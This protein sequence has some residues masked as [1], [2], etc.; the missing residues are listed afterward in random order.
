MRYLDYFTSA[1]HT[2]NIHKLKSIMT[3]MRVASEMLRKTMRWFTLLNSLIMT[4]GMSGRLPSVVVSLLQK[5]TILQM[6]KV[7]AQR[8]LRALAFIFFCSLGIKLSRTE[9]ERS[10]I[11]HFFHA[12][13]QYINRRKF[14]F[15]PNVTKAGLKP[16]RH[17]V[18]GYHKTFLEIAE[19][20]GPI[21]CANPY[22]SFGTKTIMMVS[23]PSAVQQVM[24]DK[25]TYPSRGP[26]GFTASTPLGL[27]GL[28]SGEVH[29]RHRRVIGKFM[30]NKFLMSYTDII[31]EECDVLT[32]KWEKCAKE[33]TVTNGV[34]DLSMITLQIIMR[35]SVG[36]TGQSVNMQYVDEADNE[37]YKESHY[38]L[39]E[40]LVASMFPLVAQYPSQ[41]LRRA[42]KMTEENFTSLMKQAEALNKHSK[43]GP[44]MY[45]ALK[46]SQSASSEDAF[47]EEEV[48]QEMTTI[49]GAGHETTAHT[50]SWCL[51]LLSE[52]PKCMK[53]LQAEV[54]E[55]LEGQV[56][57]Y[58]EVK[59]LE[60]THMVV[61]ETL[62]L[63]P[64]VPIFPRQ[65]AYDTKL[66]G[67]DVPKGTQV[68]IFQSPMNQNPKLWKS[69]EEFNPERFRKLPELRVS[70]AVGIPDGHAYGFIPFGAV[71]SWSCSCHN[72]R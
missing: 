46:T 47:S 48:M 61:Y 49:R 63:Y 43:L 14:R 7:T 3:R 65:A 69:P 40:I 15:P 42:I 51:L 44:T 37:E 27:L 64:T 41:R 11:G 19:K 72:S 20:V 33:K 55:V 34:Y 9:I 32:E 8:R 59:R 25:V 26:S 22:A 18:F 1:F 53:K 35:A 21:A 54:D 70:R 31:K 60:Y 29:T 45:S 2:Y 23:D 52:H 30:S 4:F 39:K 16:W 67:Y 24:T 58:E 10:I 68:F 17:G 13:S 5:L 66:M 28:P 36:I 57:T 56:P 12:F 62:R 38:G 6:I 71:S 50:L